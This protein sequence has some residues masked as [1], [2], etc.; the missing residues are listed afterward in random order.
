MMAEEELEQLRRDSNR[1][2]ELEFE[3]N[4]LE[5]ENIYLKLSNET[6]GRFEKETENLENYIIELADTIRR[7]K[8]KGNLEPGWYEDFIKYAE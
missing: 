5:N 4:E 1:C 7:W 2:S 6:L 8:S 3:K